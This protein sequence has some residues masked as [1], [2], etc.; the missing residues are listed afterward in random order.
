MTLQAV[1][2]SRT[3]T[4]STDNPTGTREFLV[5]DDDPSADAVSLNQAISKTGIKLFKRDR[6]PVLGRLIPL[7]VSVS[8]DLEGPNKFKV[9]WKYGLDIVGDT[10]SDP[11][12]PGFIDFSITQR[13]VG[14]DTYRDRTASNAGTENI[15]IDIAGEPIDSGG[16]PVTSFVYQQDLSITQRYESFADIPVGASLVTVGKRNTG[17][18][19]GAAAGF[20]LY[21]GMSV[22]RDGVNS[23]NATF[24]FTYDE[25]AHRRQVPMKDADG[26]VITENKGTTDAPEFKAK[27]VHLK[28]PFPLTADF[29]LLGV[30][31]PL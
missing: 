29:G 8:T 19:L 27:T 21:T 22:S 1:E 13:P 2:V 23:Y 16:D 7:E 11:G 31:N 5:F 4:N 30:V 12:E 26:V 3:Q 9:S 20:L 17:I 14:I 28:Q 25:F 15:D 6:A 24:T 10:S 18:F